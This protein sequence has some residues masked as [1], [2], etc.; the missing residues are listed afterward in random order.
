[1][2]LCPIFKIFKFMVNFTELE[3]KLVLHHPPGPIT[4][5]TLG[6]LGLVTIVSL[7]LDLVLA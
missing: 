5:G 4:I 1:M 3:N 6:L 2:K 7:V